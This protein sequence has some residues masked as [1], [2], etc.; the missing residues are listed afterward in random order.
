MPDSTTPLLELRAGSLRALI[1]PL[2]GGAV[3]GLWHGTT[4]VLRSSEGS[5][6]PRLSAG[7]PL[8][9]YSNRLGNRRFQWQGQAYTTAANFPDSPHS[10]H[11]VVWQRR[12]QVL[13][14]SPHELALGYLHEPD[15]D[16]PFAFRAHQR[17]LLDT[18]GL[19]LE[20]GLTNLAPHVAPLGLGWHPYFPKRAH[21][22]LQAQVAG[23]WLP[24]PTTLLPSRRVAQASLD[25]QVAA[26]NYDHCLDGWTGAAALDDGVLSLR[27]SS[28][29]KRLVVYTPP[30][31]GFYCVEPVSHVNNALQMDD[32]L[33][34]GV[35]A[36]NPGESLQAWVRLDVALA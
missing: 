3:A 10:L 13:S 23:C 31:L 35:K 24:D 14:H 15:A 12:W 4:A 5:V 2:Q 22:R 6:A 20:L 25:G 33:Q 28:C 11:G 17:F 19:R 21:S 27:L 26:M 36:V 7:F 16:W 32:P 18:T 1:D 29:L 9:P 30:A 34:H 8:M